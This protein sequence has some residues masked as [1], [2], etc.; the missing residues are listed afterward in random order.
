MSYNEN[1]LNLKNNGGTYIRAFIDGCPLD[2]KDKD[3]C[4]TVVYALTGR[5]LPIDLNS[6]MKKAKL[7]KVE[8]TTHNLKYKETFEISRGN[9]KSN[10]KD[11]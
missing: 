6:E 1:G 2:V 5:N 4:S 8:L 10:M 3:L 9:V 7:L 11:R